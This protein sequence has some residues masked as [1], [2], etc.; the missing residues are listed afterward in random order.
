MFCLYLTGDLLFSSQVTGAAAR[1][2]LPLRVVGSAEALLASCASEAVSAVVLDLSAP[3]L[4]VADLAPKLK[5]L[6]RPPTVVAYAPHVHGETL[7]AAQ[8]AG[9]DLV[10]TRGQ[11]HAQM[12]D[13][14]RRFAS[15]P[16]AAN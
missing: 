2:G 13:L 9:C 5:K 12:G 8:A 16:D 6:G 3:G 4:S 7:A 10:L 14:L 1:V 15:H 11:F